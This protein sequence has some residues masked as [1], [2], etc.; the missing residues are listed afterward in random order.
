LKS[1]SFDATKEALDFVKAAQLAASL[2]E[3]STFCLAELASF[4]PKGRGEAFF[5]WTDYIAVYAISDLVIDDE[6]M[7]FRFG[8]PIRPR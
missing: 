2:F 4:P 7:R 6:G 1:P 5:K 8:S 3:G